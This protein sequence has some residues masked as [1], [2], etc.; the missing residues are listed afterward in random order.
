MVDMVFERPLGLRPHAEFQPMQL[1]TGYNQRLN[2]WHLRP[3]KF[4]HV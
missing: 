1:A 4:R 2:Q 3:P